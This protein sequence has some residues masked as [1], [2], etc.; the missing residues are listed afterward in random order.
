MQIFKRLLPLFFVQNNIRPIL[1]FSLK[2]CQKQPLFYKFGIYFT[3]K[4]NYT[5]FIDSGIGGLST[6][7][8]AYKLLP[9]NYIYYSDNANCPYGSKTKKQIFEIVKNIILSVK[10]SYNIKVVVLAC[11]T[12]T[13][14]AIKNL[15]KTF[16]EI[17]FI[18]TEPAIKLAAG[19]GYKKIV[20]LCTP[21]TAK[22]HKY[23]SLAHKTKSKIKTI[24]MFKLASSIEAYFDTPSQKNKVWL[25]KQLYF[26]RA[27]CKNFD[28]VVLGCTHY[29][30][31]ENMVQK[32]F[33]K[34][35]INGNFGVAK[36]VLFVCTGLRQ[37]NTAFSDN[38][39]KNQISK[40]PSSNSNN[41]RNIKNSSTKNIIF[42]F[43]RQEDGIKEKYIKTFNQILAN[44]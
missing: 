21:A 27:K 9:Q 23:L 12:A 35:V 39:C 32:I 34:P 4:K 2:I 41:F 14:S 40:S 11:N 30:L 13:T 26:A 19:L 18:G 43:S 44:K 36:Q 29:V 22:Q 25:Q 10:K 16:G 15:R 8:E 28:G 20:V 24:K 31:I 3:M 38:F 37:Q 5:L 6:L 42:M 7:A 33:N 1:I 17:K